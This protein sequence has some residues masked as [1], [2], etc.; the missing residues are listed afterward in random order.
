MGVCNN[1]TAAF[2][3]G[4]KLQPVQ[5]PA[6]FPNATT[7]TPEAVPSLGRRGA[8][9]KKDRVTEIWWPRLVLC[10][11]LS[12]G[13][14]GER[15]SKQLLKTKICENTHT[16]LQHNS[17]SRSHRLSAEPQIYEPREKS[18]SLAPGPLPHPWGGGQN[19]PPTPAKA[20]LPAAK[21]SHVFPPSVARSPWKSRSWQ[22][23]AS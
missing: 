1:G 9:D 8:G 7:H 18:D 16:P 13:G 3:A 20:P 4:M 12:W 17:G 21:G 11:S 19:A 23:V 10:S 5:S 6:G 2:E 22:K 14:G 15:E